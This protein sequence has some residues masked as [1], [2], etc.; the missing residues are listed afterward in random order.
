MIFGVQGVIG[1]DLGGYVECWVEFWFKFDVNCVWWVDDVC[2]WGDYDGQ[3]GL[4]CL[5][6]VCDD[7]VCGQL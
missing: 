1:G 4:F 3:C 5:Q 2:V 6:S 7:L